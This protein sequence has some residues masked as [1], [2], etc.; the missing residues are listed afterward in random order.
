MIWLNHTGASDPIHWYE[1]MW[2]CPNSPVVGISWYEAN[3]FCRWLTLTKND[4][5]IYALP[6]LEQWMA[7]AVGKEGRK[8]PWG[9]KER[10]VCN[11]RQ[12]LYF[13]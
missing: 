4:G 12:Q 10:G 8:Y 6:S 11:N 3:A 1:Q 2:R 7:A 5:Y 9:E 13:Y